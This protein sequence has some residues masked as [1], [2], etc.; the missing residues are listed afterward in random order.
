MYPS[1]PQAW[2]VDILSDH[3]N[4]GKATSPL[5][6]PFLCCCLCAD[7]FIHSQCVTFE[8]ELTPLSLILFFHWQLSYQQLTSGLVLEVQWKEFTVG[9]ECWTVAT[10]NVMIPKSVSSPVCPAA[11][12]TSPPGSLT[13]PTQCWHLKV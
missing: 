8:K 10:T 13:D 6:T 12:W 2:E 5:L 3:P 9:R 7:S 11:Y 1:A 4:I